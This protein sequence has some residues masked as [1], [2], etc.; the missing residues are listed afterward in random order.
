M[1]PVWERLTK[2]ADVESAGAGRTL[3]QL[4]ESLEAVR[5]SDCVLTATEGAHAVVPPVVARCSRRDL[6]AVVRA[7]RSRLDCGRDA[8][9]TGSS[10]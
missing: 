2:L 6:T 7:P 8:Q 10:R 5:V 4:A 1:I 3:Q 9:R